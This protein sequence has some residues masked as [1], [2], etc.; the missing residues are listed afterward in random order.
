MIFGKTAQ[1]AYIE[2]EQKLAQALGWLI[3]ANKVLEEVDKLDGVVEA[4]K[5]FAKNAIEEIESAAQICVM[6]HAAAKAK[7]NG[8]DV[9][10]L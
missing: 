4:D 9:L 5:I 1:D 3:E 2:A 8:V 10:F 6:V 7:G